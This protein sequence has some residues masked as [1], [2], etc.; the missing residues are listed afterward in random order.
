MVGNITSANA[1][2]VMVVEN[3]FPAGVTLEQFGT[4]Q[5]FSQE[6]SQ[7]TETRMGVDG[8]M[9][10]GWI[11]TIKILTITLEASSPSFDYMVQLFRAMDKGRTIFPVTVVARIPSIDQTITWSNGVLHDANPVPAANN[12]LDPTTWIFHFQ[13][14]IVE[15]NA[16]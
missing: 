7:V 14:M 4:D 8:Q 6:Q 3:L 11:P 10:A 9:V 1:S 2:V 12:V 5:A 16:L 13:D 15:R